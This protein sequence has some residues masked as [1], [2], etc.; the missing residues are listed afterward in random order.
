MYDTE[1]PFLAASPDG[2]LSCKECPQALVEIKCLNSKRNFNP[3]LAL[4]LADV[5]K[6][7]D[8]ALVMNTKHQYYYQVQGQMALTGIHQCHLV[9]FTHKG[10]AVFTVNFDLL[11]WEIIHKK[12]TNF[13]CTAHLP[14]LTATYVKN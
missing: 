8:G 11:F 7:Q 4:V 10:I 12:L 5:C 13:L 1:Y 3:S 14:M 6:R 9:G 2:V